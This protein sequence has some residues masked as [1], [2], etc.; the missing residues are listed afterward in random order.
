[1]RIPEPGPVARWLTI[2]GLYLLLLC[3]YGYSAVFADFGDTVLGPPIVQEA[4]RTFVVV[5]IARAFTLRWDEFTPSQRLWWG[6]LGAGI[7]LNLSRGHFSDT[8]LTFSFLLIHVGLIGLTFRLM[9]VSRREQRLTAEITV[10]KAQLS[11]KET[12]DRL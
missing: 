1:M 10:L 9:A 6:L 8:P 3:A 11:D 12:H 4:L 5:H 7:A 2:T